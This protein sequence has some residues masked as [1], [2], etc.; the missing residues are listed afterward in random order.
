[1]NCGKLPMSGLYR[2]NLPTLHRVGV[3]AEVADEECP[4]GNDFFAEAVLGA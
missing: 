2:I 3:Q 4:E 1:M